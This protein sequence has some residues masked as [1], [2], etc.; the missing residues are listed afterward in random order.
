[1]EMRGILTSILMI[2]AVLLTISS[3]ATVP[4]G[5][6]EEGEVRL[7]S[8]NVPDNGVLKMGIQYWVN[9]S[10][11]ADG[12]PEIRRVCMFWSGEGPYCS[13]VKNVHYGSDAY[14]EVPLYAQPDQ[15]RLECY[16][17]YV[18]DGK[19]RRTNTVVSYVAGKS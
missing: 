7:L 6:L 8:L 10:F 4:T 18:R 11:K 5:P 2:A 15:K 3:C 13:P 17:E 16:A 1:M 12:K 14:F 19:I 9:I